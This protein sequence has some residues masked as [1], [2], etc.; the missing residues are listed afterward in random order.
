M[1]KLF[2]ASVWEIAKIVV[3]A[4]VIVLPIR[5]F[6]FQPFLVRGDSMIPNFHNGDYLIVDEISYRLQDPQRGEVVVFRF[7]ENPS[8]RYI[9]RVIGL[10]GETVE[11]KSG[12]IA[13]SMA[14]KTIALDESYLPDSTRTNG[15]LRITL[16]E[17]E[18]FVLGDNRP[19][20]SDSRM[21]GTLPEKNIIGRVWVRVLP[22]DAL[23]KI[24]RPL[25]E[26][27]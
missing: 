5:L 27:R 25:Y 23:A 26:T 9:K 18:Y 7:P 10:P 2:G 24:S 21:W 13:I 19:F 4:L 12:E 15:S 11:I 14:G 16:G 1:L 17:G 6:V 22:L 8:E 3:V 20:S